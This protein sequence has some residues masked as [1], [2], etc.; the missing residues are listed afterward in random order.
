MQNMFVQEI[1]YGPEMSLPEIEEKQSNKIDAFDADY[2]QKT[3][4][5][6]ETLECQTSFFN[7]SNKK[8]MQILKF[9]HKNEN[10]N[11]ILPIQRIKKEFLA[12]RRNLSAMA[13]KLKRFNELMI[14]R[15]AFIRI[16]LDDLE[17][18]INEN[19]PVSEYQNGESQWG[20][21]KSQEF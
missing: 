10:K 15:K 11:D 18:A 4:I 14:H 2:P 12:I 8:D 19:C 9:E 5:G 7:N 21:K 3:I 13:P 16:T 1:I 6:P 20:I 17:Q